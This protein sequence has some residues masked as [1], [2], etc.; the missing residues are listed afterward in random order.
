MAG[1]S[2]KETPRSPWLR[3]LFC[4][5]LPLAAPSFA[6]WSALDQKPAEDEKGYDA[7][8]W[9]T[10][11][12][13]PWE[14]LF[15]RSF[16]S[17]E[18]KQQARDVFAPADPA[19]IAVD[20]EVQEPAIETPV[21]EEPVVAPA[22]IEEPEP[23]P[24]EPWAELD[25]PLYDAATLPIPVGIPDSRRAAR[26]ADR[27][28]ARTRFAAELV[29][30][31]STLWRRYLEERL[32]YGQ[33]RPGPW[34]AAAD[35]VVALQDFDLA[36]ALA[37][38]LT[39]PADSLVNQVAQ[40][41]LAELFGHDFADL[42]DFESFT[43]GLE[44]T[45]AT[46]RVIEELRAERE[47]SRSRLLENF[48]YNRAA[49][50]DHLDDPDPKTRLGAAKVLASALHDGQVN[51][52]KVLPILLT[53]AAVERSPEVAEVLLDA[54]V[55]SLAGRPA[56]DDLI[57]RLRA[58]LSAGV[59]GNADELELLIARTLARLPWPGAEAVDKTSLEEGAGLIST[60]L[61][62]VNSED[63]AA[64][65]DVTL[66]ILQAL[67]SMCVAE[68]DD[69]ATAT[70][71]ASTDVRLPLLA[72][73]FDDRA[74]TAS[75]VVAVG[76]LPRVAPPT[77]LLDLIRLVSTERTESAEL[78]IGLRFAAM[79]AMGRFAQRGDA[80]FEG[81]GALAT[82][83][84]ENVSRSE[85]DL[86]R[87]A[88]V[89]LGEDALEHELTGRSLALFIRRLGVEDEPDLQAELMSLIGR[90]GG[91]EDLA[92]VLALGNFDQLAAQDSASGSG[93]AGL[94]ER[95]AGGDSK[96]V[97]ESAAR[98]WNVQES[99]GQWARR[100]EALGLVARL[101]AEAAAALNPDQHRTVANWAIQL[102]EA[103]VSLAATMPGGADFLERL[104]ELH[105]PKSG[106]AQPFGLAE[107]NLMAALFLSD[108]ASARGNGEAARLKDEVLAKFARAEELAANHP[109]AEFAYLVRRARA[110]FLVSS[111]TPVPP[112]A[113]ADFLFVFDSDFRGL[114]DTADLRS[115]G[116]L[117]SEATD[118]AQD[119]WR[120]SEALVALASW[121]AEPVAVRVEDLRQLTQR[122]ESLGDAATLAAAAALFADLPVGVELPA[123][124]LPAGATWAG[125]LAD[126]AV[127]AE[128]AGLRASLDEASRQLAEAAPKPAPVEAPAPV[129]EPTTDSIVV[130]L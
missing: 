64:D 97:F 127:R 108:L 85:A 76:T 67:D 110:R 15:M 10:W 46:L 13:K 84:V 105:L 103:G 75:R 106:S 128:L 51:T 96:L 21:V 32:R 50:S 25:L 14:P 80:G 113:L 4:L 5:T 16:F 27:D 39:A 107:Q 41:A 120:F 49:A 71:L 112:A 63:A 117:A 48:A 58:E 59:R 35:L 100:G 45:G 38:G 65:P 47:R 55:E 34:S 20:P 43:D 79:G 93:L 11:T 82:C 73:A 57:E 115:A 54:A 40:G 23:A 44:P 104:V 83:L 1:K 8:G 66:G 124:G 114:L 99:V 77:G 78:P 119:A 22:G 95:L 36:P 31:H 70:R 69:L 52:A 123:G 42:A 94:L 26:S 2:A 88:L 81:L 89:L 6:S 130:P 29:G 122:A 118:G 86:R 101:S 109:T 121:H 68:G 28:A 116:Q 17:V 53:R 98:L 111:V 72:L 9:S 129:K 18:A 126:E 3:V 60:L 74:E 33:D 90:Y 102:R 61:R 12:G 24:A 92:G 30:E 56:G 19:P 87:R 7:S 37:T 91:P 62:R 125:L